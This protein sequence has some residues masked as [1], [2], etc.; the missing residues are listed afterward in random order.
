MPSGSLTFLLTFTGGG[1]VPISHAQETLV[2]L[3]VDFKPNGILLAGD[4]GNTVSPI[5]GGGIGSSMI[6]GREAAKAMFIAKVNGDFNELFS[7]NRGYIKEYGL[8]QARQLMLMKQ[9]VLSMLHS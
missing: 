2:G 5:D 1:V 4:A 9:M 7:Y 8:K 3:N 6:A